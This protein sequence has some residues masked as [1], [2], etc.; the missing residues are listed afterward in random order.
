[1][2]WNRRSATFRLSRIWIRI[3]RFIRH[4]GK[5]ERSSRSSNGRRPIRECVAVDPLMTVAL[6]AVDPSQ[7][8]SCCRFLGLPGCAGMGRCWEGPARFGSYIFARRFSM[9]GGRLH[10]QEAHRDATAAVMAV[11][12]SSPSQDSLNAVR[13]LPSVAKG[14]GCSHGAKAHLQRCMRDTNW[15]DRAGRAERS[16]SASRNLLINASPCTR[17]IPSTGLRIAGRW[18]HNRRERR[19]PPR[20]AP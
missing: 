7:R 10:G 15:A 14:P 18:P 13:G 8:M 20:A 2:F 17:K 16:R 11:G 9:V 3:Q 4:G 12:Y 6:K 5:L 19:S 1:M